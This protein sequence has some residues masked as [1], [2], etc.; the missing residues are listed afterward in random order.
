[1]TQDNWT[2]RLS[3]YLDGTLAVGER[4][5]LEAHL[6]D[7]AA[8]TATLEE[9]RRVVARARAL[10]DRAPGADR[11][12]K[13]AVGIGRATAPPARRYFAFTVPQLIA[14][15]V[16]LIILSG[17]ATWLLRSRAVTATPVAIAPPQAQWLTAAD[18]RYETTVGE[19]QGALVAGR[20]TGRRQSPGR[21]LE[22][23][24]RPGQRVGGG[25]ERQVDGQVRSVPGHRLHDH[26]AR[27]D[28]ARAVGGLYRHHGRGV[29][30]G[31]HGR[32]GAG[33][34]QGDGRV[35]LRVAAVR[36]RRGDTRQGAR[37]Y[38]AQYGERG[39]HAA[40]RVGRRRRRDR[41]RR[42]AARAHRVGQRGGEHGERRDHLRGHDQRERAVPLRHARRRPRHRDPRERER[43]GVGLDLRRRLRGVLPG[44]AH[45]QD[46]A[47][48]QLHDRLGE[49]AAPARDLLR[50]P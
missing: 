28:G 32:D 3:E 6:V 39:N 16:A 10:D 41:E 29:A 8:C 35:G 36:E 20:R 4:A 27:V 17:G 5:A 31:N 38:H 46:E 43:G 37:P 11:W 13:I 14:A 26:G 45:R 9:L 1:M 25:G 19:L 50:R 44:N 15:S 40:R 23:R 49:R 24:P 47:P 18:R 7:C 21:A 22:P 33:R 12:R 42:R 48:L 30:G 34:G 2:D